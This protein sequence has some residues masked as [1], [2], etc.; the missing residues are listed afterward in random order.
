MFSFWIKTF[1]VRFDTHR[2]CNFVRIFFRIIY[3]LFFQFFYFHFSFF[4]FF[5]FVI[6]FFFD[7]QRWATIL[8]YRSVCKNQRKT[9]FYQS[10]TLLSPTVN[11]C[12]LGVHCYDVCNIALPTCISVNCV[13]N[14]LNVVRYNVQKTVASYKTV[15][16]FCSDIV[17]QN[18]NVISTCKVLCFKKHHH[19]SPI[20][21]FILEPSPLTVRTSVTLPS[22][23][24]VS[25]SSSALSLISSS[26]FSTSPSFLL[27]SLLSPLSLN[28]PSSWSSSSV[29]F[30]ISLTSEVCVSPSYLN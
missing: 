23:S 29:S 7:W 1:F 8:V 25:L 24:P 21:C 20:T 9:F 18:V 26:S 11:V 27:S 10:S 17:L 16:L 19:V 22:L 4:I 2:P 6:F 13:E 28:P 12:K 15:Q 5:I 30:Y 3:F 14:P